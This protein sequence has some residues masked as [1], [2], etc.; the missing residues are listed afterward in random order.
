M[1]PPSPS[2]VFSFRT[3]FSVIYFLYR[4][5]KHYEIEAEI[6][7]IMR[8]IVNHHVNIAWFLL[9]FSHFHLI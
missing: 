6:M 7:K 2:D 5:P 9:D 3:L 1:R 4:K 8:I